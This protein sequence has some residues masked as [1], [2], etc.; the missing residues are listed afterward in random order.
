MSAMRNT[1]LPMATDFSSRFTGRQL[2]GRFSSH[3]GQFPGRQSVTAAQLLQLRVE[4]RAAFCGV[5][6]RVDLRPHIFRESGSLPQRKIRIYASG[7]PAPLNGF[8]PDPAGPIASSR[9]R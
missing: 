3:S 4:F 2:F 5:L 9:S 6:Y 1:E 8:Q 7:G